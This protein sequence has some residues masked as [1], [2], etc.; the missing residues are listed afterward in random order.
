[1]A[2]CVLDSELGVILALLQFMAANVTAANAALNVSERKQLELAH[3]VE[4]QRKVRPRRGPMDPALRPEALCIHL[5]GSS[6][7]AS[8]DGSVICNWK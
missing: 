3:A 4:Q 7:R 5:V 2:S 8:A 1:M 6:P